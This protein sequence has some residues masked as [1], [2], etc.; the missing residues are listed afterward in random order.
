MSEFP[1]RPVSAALGQPELDPPFTW[2][3]HPDDQPM[4]LYAR[5]VVLSADR[6]SWVVISGRVGYPWLSPD[7]VRAWPY[8]SDIVAGAAVVKAQRAAQAAPREGL[9]QPAE[10]GDMGPEAFKG[11]SDDAA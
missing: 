7:E 8:T 10:R 6:W 3:V 1:D 9:V 5:R 4:D 11:G 2:R